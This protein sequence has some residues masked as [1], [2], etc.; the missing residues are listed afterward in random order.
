[1]PN[2]TVVVAWVSRKAVKI[3]LYNSKPPSLAT[4]LGMAVETMVASMAT[5]NMPT[6]MQT[7]TSARLVRGSER[8]DIQEPSVTRAA[9]RSLS[10][11]GNGRWPARVQAP[12]AGLDKTTPWRWNALPEGKRSMAQFA[13]V[14][15]DREWTVFKDAQ[16]LRGCLTRSAAV[17]AAKAMAFE[18]EARGETVELIIQDYYGAVSETRSGGPDD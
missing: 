14:L 1:M 5:M 13:V 12:T 11:A 8:C 6:A 10:D 17:A 9:K 2:I 18:A 15:K 4:M 16:A 7:R 3:Q